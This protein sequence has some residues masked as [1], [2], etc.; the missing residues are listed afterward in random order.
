MLM[1]AF[2]AVVQVICAFVTL[3]LTVYVA[4]RDTKHLKKTDERL[5]TAEKL[6]QPSS[7]AAWL[8]RDATGD[9]RIVIR[10]DSNLPVYE[11]VATIV[12]THGAGCCK[13]EDLES[14]YQ[15]RKILDLIPPGL[16]SVSIDMGGFYGMHRH[17]LVEIAFVCAKGKSW[18]RRGD[19]A[20]DEL[21]VSPFNYY[22]LGLPID[23]DSIAPY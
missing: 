20:L 8:E 10:N 21:D 11:V 7:I 2:C 23:F 13:G 1:V 12:V 4:L 22:E 19:G 15:Y 5:K 6:A 3:C 17:P 16:H 18:V 14:P 9:A